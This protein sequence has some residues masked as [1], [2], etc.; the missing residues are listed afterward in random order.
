MGKIVSTT[1]GKVEGE[2]RNGVEIFRGIPYGDDCG[3]EKRFLEPKPAK[4]WDGVRD[5]TKNGP[6]AVQYGGS[7][8]GSE[9]LGPYFSGGHPELFGVLEEEQGEDCLVLNIVTPD[10]D[11]KKRPVL[12]YIHGGGFANGSGS[13][14]LGSDRFVKDEDIVVV[15]VNHRLNVL[16]YLYL[17]AFDEKYKDSGMAGMLDLV[18]ALEWV[19]D[20]IAAFG[21]DPE[22]VTIMGES[23]GAMKVSTL[24]AMPKAKGLFR[25]AV[26]ESGSS[27]VG[28]ISVQEATETTRVWLSRLGVDEQNLDMLASMPVEKM[29]TAMIMD[30]DTCSEL[31]FG[32]VADNINLEYQEE[33][34]IKAFECSREI[35]IMIGASEDEMGVFISMDMVK[36]ITWDNLEEKLVND[37]IGFHGHFEHRSPEE[38]RNI[39]KVF[40][41]ADTKNISAAMTF[42]KIKSMS[43]FLGGGAF[44]QAMAKASQKGAPV[45]HYAIAYDS[46]L[47]GKEDVCCAWHTA[48]LPLQLK[49]VLNKEQEELSEKL[50]G[51]LAA[52]VRSGNPSTQALPWPAFETD[53]RL[54]MVFDDACRVEVDPW[55]EMREVLNS[56]K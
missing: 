19:R 42:I 13:L 39:V 1:L 46:P 29:K 27:A 18:L 16:G 4:K 48:D 15:G 17:G 51:A 43:G 45:Y 14:V 41:N 44:Y 21:G 54:T 26:I 6:I 28:R 8:S 53:T 25:H 5:C 50:S 24:M 31:S 32:P 49:I 36:D 11:E 33:E 56:I 37:P 52:F 12:F 23:G 35:P 38:A 47:P 3:G 2:N 40:R 7:I 20:N 55:K 10:C 34:E 22:K 9:G 30:G